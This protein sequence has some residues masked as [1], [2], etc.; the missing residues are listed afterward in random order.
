MSY[1]IRMNKGRYARSL[2]EDR[3]R[4]G[5]GATKEKPARLVPGRLYSESDPAAGKA[6]GKDAQ[7]VTEVT[8]L[9]RREATPIMPKPAIISAQLAGSGT[10]PPPPGLLSLASLP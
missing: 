5:R 9:R 8:R 1:P 2:A 4:L 3:L 6:A 7:A 10:V